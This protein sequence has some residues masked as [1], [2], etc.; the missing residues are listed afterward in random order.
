MSPQVFLPNIQ[1]TK[2][3]H[4]IKSIFSQR[5]LQ[6]V[7][8]YHYHFGGGA[9][10][11]GGAAG[12]AARLS[13]DRGSGSGGEQDG[14]DGEAR[15]DIRGFRQ[16]TSGMQEDLLIL[17]DILR[18]ASP[19]LD[20]SSKQ[21]SRQLLALFQDKHPGCMESARS[22]LSKLKESS[23]QPSNHTT[24]I[25]EQPKQKEPIQ[26][27]QPA[28]PKVSKPVPDSK[29][30]P[31]VEIM[32]D[33]EG[34]TD[35]NLGM[36]R[37]FISCMD[38]ARRKYADMKEVDPGM[39]L[40]P[41]LLAEWKNMYPV[42]EETVKTFLVRIR[43]L[44]SNK[45]SIKA[46]LGQH[47]LLP[48]MSQEEVVATP[49]GDAPPVDT[50]EGSDKEIL[51]E[52]PAMETPSLAKFV[53]DANTMMPIVIATRAKAIAKQKKEASQGRRVSYAKI[54]IKEFKKVYPTCPYTAN[55][56]SVHFWYWTSKDHDKKEGSGRS[57]APARDAPPD[58][59]D[60]TP[61]K[62]T[63]L[64]RVGAKVD[65]MLADAVGGSGK[66]MQFGKL[67]HSVWVKLHPQT[68]QSEASL[69][70]ALQR[71]PELLHQLEQSQQSQ[72][73]IQGG[74]EEQVEPRPAQ[75]WTPHHNA[76]LRALVAE[77]RAE[78][79]GFT[80]PGLLRC[81]RRSQPGHNITW[82]ALAARLEDCSLP[83][84]ANIRRVR[85]STTQPATPP[86]QS[87]RA[88]VLPETEPAPSGLNARGQMRWSQQAVSDLLECHKLGLKAKNSSPDRKLADLVHQKFLQRHPYCPIAPNVLLTKC[89][90]LR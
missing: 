65:S 21:F 52:S 15:E 17:R 64:K 34:F 49:A 10:A 45:E 68:R 51:E 90:I 44:K 32:S 11:G 6:V 24:T 47:D 38:R 67:L 26:L 70:S 12:R 8:R 1:V 81:W 76:A 77:L 28:K 9:D 78:P 57:A 19:E 69:V 18:E 2:S 14:E 7:S 88:A 75:P 54:W 40:V 55:N 82:A 36:V 25:K 83:V 71:L 20:P 87:P 42:S 37:D 43:F 16:W 27:P 60:W 5:H 62:L 31:A 30:N 22:L 66:Q 89:Y 23:H 61:E 80:R 35:W 63:E 86:T 79:G 3:S 53:W 56:L 29:P 33:I 74:Q 59:T 50:T 84:P 58:I 85:P 48:R 13:T 4:S 73:Q 72:Q 46:R 39:K 41:L